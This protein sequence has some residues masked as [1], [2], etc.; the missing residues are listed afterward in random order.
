M[1]LFLERVKPLLKEGLNF[2]R[3]IKRLPL[4]LTIG[5]FSIC[6]YQVINLTWKVAFP[7]NVH[8]LITSNSSPTFSTQHSL[9]NLSGDPFLRVANQVSN[10]IFSFE[11][12]ST[13]LSLRLYG[14]RYADS[15]EADAA[16]LGFNPNN[17]K[18]CQ[19]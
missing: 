17:Q 9:N 15:G 1:Q 6:L 13:T 3:T 12:P 4:Y 8:T 19:N 18:L 14:I 7:D 10:Q 16:I 2:M 11:V 5:F